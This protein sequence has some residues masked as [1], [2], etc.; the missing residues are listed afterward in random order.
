MRKEEMSMVHCFQLSGMGIGS[1]LCRCIHFP[2]HMANPLTYGNIQGGPE[3][4]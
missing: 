2:R 3:R 4:G 1:I